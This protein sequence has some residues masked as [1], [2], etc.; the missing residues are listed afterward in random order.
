[1]SFGRYLLSY[2]NVITNT[3]ITNKKFLKMDALCE[4]VNSRRKPF[5]QSQNDGLMILSKSIA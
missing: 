3:S 1:M 2:I 4:K 5:L